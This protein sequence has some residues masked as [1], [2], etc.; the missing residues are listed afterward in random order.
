MKHRLNSSCRSCQRQHSHNHYLRHRVKYYERRQKNRKL[1]VTKNKTRVL[2][3]LMRA[4]CTDC[5]NRDRIVLDFDHVR[6]KKLGNISVMVGLGLRWERIEEEIAKCEIRCANCHRRHTV[7]SISLLRKDRAVA[8]PGRALRLGRRGSQVRSLSA[9][10]Y[11]EDQRVSEGDVLKFCPRCQQVKLL[12]FFRPRTSGGSQKTS[13]CRPCERIYNREYYRRVDAPKQ[14]LRVAKNDVLYRRRNQDMVLEYLSKH[15][16]VDCG[17]S[18]P[19]VLEFDHVR[20]RKLSTVSKLKSS[21]ARWCKVLAEI[22]KCD[23]RCVNCHRRRTFE[24][25]NYN[26]Q[27]K[28]L[29]QAPVAQLDRAPAF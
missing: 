14:L 26:R 21:N 7:Q 16:C 17:E 22:E 12:S 13:Y 24:Q 5:G 1:Y 27:S 6:G 11:F 25:F 15:P 10:S 3:I 18:D 4:A 20:G 8:Q 28:H 23:V 2:Q 19:V 29:F 9:R